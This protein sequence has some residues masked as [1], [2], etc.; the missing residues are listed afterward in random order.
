MSTYLQQTSFNFYCSGIYSGTIRFTDQ[1]VMH[2]KVD[3]RRRTQMQEN[4]LDPGTK[5][6]LP[7]S[8]IAGQLSSYSSAEW[9]GDEVVLENGDRYQKHIAYQAEIS[10]TERTSQVWAYRG[11]TA[12]DIVTVDGEVIA[13]VTPNR[14]GLEL[15]VRA[16]YEPLTPLAVYTEPLCR[17]RSTV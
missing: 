9:A 5:Y 7:L 1:A 3:A 16:G 10:G 6:V 13:F 4:V 17:S 2:A 11:G 14:Y 8:K 12:L 15:I